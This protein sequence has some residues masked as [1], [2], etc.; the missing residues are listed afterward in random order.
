MLQV[1]GALVPPLIET[2]FRH[3]VKPAP[4]IFVGAIRGTQPLDISRAA[5]FI[6]E[7]VMDKVGETALVQA[8]IRRF[9]D[10]LPLIRIG[11]WLVRAGCPKALVAPALRHQ[12][13]P[14][15]ALQVGNINVSI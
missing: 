8:D 12:L 4:G 13:L 5:N 9:Y 11:Y 15:V 3:I 1:L 6:L 2:Y 7:K 10:S 14:R